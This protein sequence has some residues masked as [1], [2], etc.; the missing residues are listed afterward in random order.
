MGGVGSGRKKKLKSGAPGTEGVK[1]AWDK[2]AKAS[3]DQGK[4]PLSADE[5]P[6]RVELE[7]ATPLTPTGLLYAAQKQAAAQRTLERLDK[8]LADLKEAQKDERALAVKERSQYAREVESGSSWSVVP[9]V[10]VHRFRDRSVSI[11]RVGP[12]GERGEFVRDRA[13]TPAELEKSTFEVR[14]DAERIDVPAGV[15]VVH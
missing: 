4:L 8:A 6:V 14:D 12:D 7:L 11:Y 3:G 5:E 9:C 1:E 2:A 13:M 10:E 15:D